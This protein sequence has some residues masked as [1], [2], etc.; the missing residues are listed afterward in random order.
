[1]NVTKLA[2]F[3]PTANPPNAA[4]GTSV[5]MLAPFIAIAAPGIQ[6]V[7][8]YRW[9]GSAWVDSG[10]I[11]R[12]IS[13]VGTRFGSS[14]A[15]SGNGL[16]LAIGS[17]YNNSV[18]VYYRTSVGAAW[19][20]E[21]TVTA[22]D[23]PVNS[24]SAF[25]SSLAMFSNA[26][27]TEEVL[28]VGAPILV[29]AS[30]IFTRTGTT[31]TQRQK[32]VSDTPNVTQGFGTSVACDFYTTVAIGAPNALGSAGADQGK[33]YIYSRTPN[34]YSWTLK[35]IVVASDAHAGDL[36]GQSISLSQFVLLIG[37]PNADAPYTDTGKAYLVNV[38]EKYQFL[39]SDMLSGSHT[40]K[41]V[42]ISGGYVIMGGPNLSVGANSNAGAV[43]YARQTGG[44]SSW[45]NIQAELAPVINPN[46]NF[47]TSVAIASPSIEARAL[48]LVG[49]PG[50]DVRASNAG[51]AFL[52]A[53]NP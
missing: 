26:G 39:S 29:E 10:S 19:T 14:L 43:F 22:N 32:L 36:Y 27:Y 41:T 16:R 1:M 52:Y 40:G 45:S 38:T 51:A 3:F 13:E 28:V 20:L 48:F 34:T 21:A 35:S 30:Y 8:T 18:Y 7:Y 15:I 31:W 53:I 46:D 24:L 6:T 2:E 11:F 47:G 12:N 4:Y 5:A 42:S 23:I 17:P 25:G 50:N 37:A 9:N 49:S 44:L 33:V